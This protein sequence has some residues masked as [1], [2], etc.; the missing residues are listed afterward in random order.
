MDFN[1]SAVASKD[2]EWLGI[3]RDGGSRVMV[4]VRVR[5]RGHDSDHTPEVFR[6]T[7]IRADLIRTSQPDDSQ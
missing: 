7:E 6:A 4:R 1:L 5:V 3:M 2:Q